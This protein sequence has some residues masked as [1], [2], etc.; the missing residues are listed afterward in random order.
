MSL[1]AANCNEL[2]LS[3]DDDFSRSVSHRTLSE[4]PGLATSAPQALTA[5]AKQVHLAPFARRGII[6]TSREPQL[7]LRAHKVGMSKSVLSLIG[8][9]LLLLDIFKIL[10]KTKLALTWALETFSCLQHTPAVGGNDC[11]SGK[12]HSG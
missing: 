10:D 7:A 5:R 9:Y 2:P 1:V 3:A 4:K 8:F 12:H 6:P 11:P